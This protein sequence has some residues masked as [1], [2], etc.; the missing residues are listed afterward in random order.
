MSVWSA[1]ANVG[2]EITNTRV[3]TPA[4]I[5]P[6]TEL[7]KTRRR[8][9]SPLCLDS[10][11]VTGQKCTGADLPIV[12]SHRRIILYPTMVTQNTNRI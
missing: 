7:I 12:K 3:A 8:M 11:G 5:T 6:K 2:T 10:G 1:E 4:M 9:F